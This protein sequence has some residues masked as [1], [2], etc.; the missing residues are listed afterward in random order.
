MLERLNA[1]CSCEWVMLGECEHAGSA[2]I[3]GRR[4]ERRG[5]TLKHHFGFHESCRCRRRKRSYLIA[6]LE[7]QITH[8]DKMGAVMKNPEMCFYCVTVCYMLRASTRTRTN[9]RARDKGNLRFICYCI[10]RPLFMRFI[11]NKILNYT[12][13]FIHN[14]IVKYYLYYNKIIYAYLYALI[15]IICSYYI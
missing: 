15:F 5:L 1:Q 8:T 14:N 11:E 6:L 4:R 7:A 3:A 9:T 12:C 13:Y 2:D 10:I